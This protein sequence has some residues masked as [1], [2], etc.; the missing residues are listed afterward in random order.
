[1]YL[2][3]RGGMSRGFSWDIKFV[4]KKKTPGHWHEELLDSFPDIINVES[5]NGQ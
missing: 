3:L 1:M 2:C 4:L 5:I